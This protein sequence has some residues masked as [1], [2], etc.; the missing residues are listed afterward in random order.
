MNLVFDR[1]PVGGGEMVL[2]LK[3]ADNAH[4]NGTHIYP[5]VATMA[6]KTRQSR[7]TV[8]YQL[9]R[10]EESGWLIKVA[11][12]RGGR[13]EAGYAAEYRIDP[14]WI[15]GAEIAPNKLSTG[16]PQKGA[17]IAPIKEKKGRNLRQKRAQST[18]QKGAIAVA[19]Q[20]SL[21][22]IEPKAY[23]SRIARL[24]RAPKAKKEPEATARVEPADV[25]KDIHLVAEGVDLK[26]ARSWLTQRKVKKLPL[27]PSAWDLTKQEAAKAGLTPAQAVE[28]AAGAGWAGF[29]A[30]WWKR[31]QAEAAKPVPAA[32]ESGEWYANGAAS[33]MKKG[34]ELGIACRKDMVLPDYLVLVAK[35]AG[36]GPWIDHVLK[37]ARKGNAERYQR[38]VEY[39][40]DALLPADFVG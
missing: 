30:A 1:Y 34:E 7:R 40:G 37:E 10:M 18:T 27:T 31:D 20:Q 8:Q 29:K 36:R 12:G 3:L 24:P 39:F 11:E 28:Y 14:E 35:A 32:A 38:I 17:E 4:D 33:I 19:P 21:T 13:G 15:K 22:V 16:S 9:R 26:H 6:L 23:T 25:L 2:A 5:S